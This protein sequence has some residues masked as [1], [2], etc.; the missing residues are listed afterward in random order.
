MVPHCGSGPGTIP[1]TEDDVE[2]YHKQFK[3]SAFLKNLG[4]I[5]ANLFQPC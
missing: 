4:M 1:W 3:F 2:P 5:G